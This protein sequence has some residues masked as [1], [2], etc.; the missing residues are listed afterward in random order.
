M[1]AGSR[2]GCRPRRARLTYER[3]QALHGETVLTIERFE[4]ELTHE[5]RCLHDSACRFGVKV[6]RLRVTPHLRGTS[7][8]AP[9]KPSDRPRSATTRHGGG[10]RDV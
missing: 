3:E 1:I 9:H 10:D 7:G 5:R 2:V 8:T 4:H 6:Q